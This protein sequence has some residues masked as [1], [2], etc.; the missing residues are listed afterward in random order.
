MYHQNC[1][2]C[3]KYELLIFNTHRYSN[4]KKVIQSIQ[5]SQKYGQVNYLHN[6]IH[7][8][9]RNWRVGFETVSNVSDI[10]STSKVLSKSMKRMFG[11]RCVVLYENE[12]INKLNSKQIVQVKT[13]GHQQNIQSSEVQ[14][15]K[16]TKS[17]IHISSWN[18][19]GLSLNK[20]LELGVILETYK[21]DIIAIQES[22]ENKP[23]KCIDN[24]GVYKWLGKPREG[25]IM[26]G[27]VGFYVHENIIPYVQIITESN[28]SEAL[29]IKLQGNKSICNT[30]LA[31]I[32]I[33]TQNIS[34][35]KRNEYFNNLL[36]DI[37]YFKTKGNII[38]MGDFNARVGRSAV[39]NDNISKFGEE[40]KNRNGNMLIQFLRKNNLYSLNNRNTERTEYTRYDKVTGERSVLDYIIVDQDMYEHFKYFEVIQEDLLSDHYVL[41]ATLNRCTEIGKTITCKKKIYK[42]RKD[43][44]TD[45]SVQEEFFMQIDKI[46]LDYIT[47]IDPTY[48]KYANNNKEYTEKV[49]AAFQ[50]IVTTASQDTIG[51]KAIIK[52]MAKHWWDE[53][54]RQ[55]INQRRL[56]YQNHLHAP[57]DQSW[58]LYKSMRSK[59]SRLIRLKK[60]KTWKS[61]LNK[62]CTN[63][64]LSAQ[65][66]WSS[67]NIVSR[68]NINNDKQIKCLKDDSGNILHR[69]EDIMQIFQDH[70]VKQYIN[71]N[72]IHSSG[73]KGDFDAAFKQ[74]VQHKVQ[75]YELLSVNSMY[76]QE[77]DEPFHVKEVWKAICT[78]KNNKA[79]SNSSKPLNEMYKIG[80]IPM[81]HMITKLFN[82][83]WELEEIPD[84]WQ[85]GKI[86]NLHKGGDKT[87]VSNYRGIHLLDALGQLYNKIIK[88]RLEHYVS[89]NEILHN[90]QYGFQKG[91]STIDLVFAL[92]EIIKGRKKEGQDTS[93]FFL[94]IQKAYD[95]MW[96]DGLWH[97][98]WKAGIKGKMWRVI[99]KLHENLKCCTIING[100]ESPVFDN[101]VGV[102]QG[103]TLAPLLFCIYIN[104][105]IKKINK[106][107]KGITIDSSKICTLAF[108]DDLVILEENMIELQNTI[109]IIFKYSKKWQ[110]QANV[111]K[112]A[113][114]SVG[115]KSLSEE[116]YAVK[117]GNNIIA[118]VTTYKYLGVVMDG[119]GG[120][121]SHAQYVIHKTLKCIAILSN[122][123]KSKHIRSDIKCTV[124][125]TIVHPILLYGSQVWEPN[126]RYVEK[127]ESVHMQAL[128][129]I[130]NYP[131]ATRYDIIRSELGIK[132]MISLREDYKVKYWYRI[133]NSRNINLIHIILNKNWTNKIQ[134]Y[135][136]IMW[137]HRIL[138]IL[139]RYEIAPN[140]SGLSKK[141]WLILYYSNKIKVER[142]EI[143]RGQ[144]I[145]LSLYKSIVQFNGIQNYLKGIITKGVQLRFMCRA[146]CLPV[147]V[148]VNRI[149]KITGDQMCKCCGVKEETMVHLFTECTYFKQVRYI[150]IYLILVHCGSLVIERL[151]SLDVSDRGVCIY[152]ELIK[153]QHAGCLGMNEL[154]C[155]MFNKLTEI[156][157]LEIWDGR[158][159]IEDS[160]QEHHQ[161]IGELAD[162]G[163]V[164]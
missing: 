82:V 67:I 127:L 48:A 128:K 100:V 164:D 72:S 40:R 19:Q 142:L 29:W 131:K 30:Y 87:K 51:Q 108:A 109:D 17:E 141:A 45:P 63:E 104:G 86:I 158:N 21:V 43:R 126:K 23:I 144:S 68:R 74:K 105:L 122:F 138:K 101:K 80:G 65:S 73:V 59:V 24:T 20:Q 62:L 57:T 113:V 34:T 33:P 53:E 37:C 77:L 1:K 98:L 84:I 117:W 139:N 12:S 110:F 115:K 55:S 90:S 93:L 143:E 96:R 140:C 6:T 4:T 155:H 154:Q 151:S 92:S 120:W 32:Y 89:T 11:G 162:I 60:N 14:L 36:H 16:H 78:L 161:G 125:K 130:L 22:W 10:A 153:D 152:K 149:R 133:S 27:G 41:R 70:Y 42:W 106:Y 25:D 121:D 69:I 112:S 15:Q 47:S 64:K 95:S 81:A 13:T 79:T 49:V 71:T 3:N 156:Y 2:I 26:H 46:H 18:A 39:I 118:K 146:S 66:L 103:S 116:E 31:S 123:L 107:S 50:A 99:K 111:A 124:I 94:D 8:V 119:S 91:K 52:G 28:Y 157:L 61:H 148:Q 159:K 160:R 132:S 129:L 137:K 150:L 5:E 134:G 135:K 44:I 56:C 83:I 85:T 136:Q 102:Q 9:G 147:K 75:Q 88:N 97:I 145:S 58:Q 38:L 54:V 76:V 163:V 35:D 114:M 7:R